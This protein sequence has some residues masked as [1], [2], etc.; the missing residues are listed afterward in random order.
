MV[1]LGA[2]GDLARR[3]LMPALFHLMGDG[4]LSDD[5]NIVGVARGSITDDSFRD[6]MQGALAESEEAGVLERESWNR[7]A[8]H[9]V[10]VSGDLGDPATYAV[11][12]ERLA[13][14]ERGTGAKRGRLF[15]LAL[16]P[17]TYRTVIVHLSESGLVPR[18]A[19]PGATPWARIVIEKPFGRDLESARARKR[20]MLERF[21]EQK[22]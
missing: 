21:A 18:L 20:V 8:E 14:L 11:I 3:K 7:F 6:A 1:I 10:A 9:L 17:S 4:L 19:D 22:V 15:Y 5:F 2:G 16:P 12:R 13:A